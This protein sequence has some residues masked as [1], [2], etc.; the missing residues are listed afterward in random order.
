MKCLDFSCQASITDQQAAAQRATTPHDGEQV[1]STE[2]V[3]VVVVVVVVSNSRGGVLRAAGGEYKG[4][5]SEYLSPDSRLAQSFFFFSIAVSQPIK[6]KA[7]FDL[8]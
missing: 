1:N 4:T 6:T 2:L 7:F 8:V 5:C 3:V